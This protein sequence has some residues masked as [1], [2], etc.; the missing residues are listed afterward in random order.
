MDIHQ[1]YN[2]FLADIKHLFCLTKSAN[3]LL[4][5]VK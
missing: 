1:K 2:D 5:E 3:M 4:Y